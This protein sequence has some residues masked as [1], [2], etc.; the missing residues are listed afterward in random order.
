MKLQP[1]KEYCMYAKIIIFKR[2]FI[3]YM[4]FLCIWYRRIYNS[5]MAP[6]VAF[7]SYI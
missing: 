1:I 3:I 6:L 2:R 5:M 4:D 7:D